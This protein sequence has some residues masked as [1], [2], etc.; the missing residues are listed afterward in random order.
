MAKTAQLRDLAQGFGL[1][2]DPTR[3][4]IL[5]LLA[6]GT[7]NITAACKA[8][9]LKQPTLSY[10]LGL[11]RMGRLVNSIRHGRTVVYVTDKA[12]LKALAYA[13]TRLMPK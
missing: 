5:T 11:L 9:R 1:L 13:M 4:G 6:K 2:S 7:T 3:L 10:H 12:N 8:L